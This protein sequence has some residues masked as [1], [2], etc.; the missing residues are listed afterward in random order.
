MRSS[1][2]LALLFPGEVLLLALA[3]FFAALFYWRLRLRQPA[4]SRWLHGVMAFL[5]SLPVAYLALL[6][7][8]W[9]WGVPESW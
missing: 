1:G 8:W 2:M 6:T 9:F 3:A 5:A 4:R 7:I